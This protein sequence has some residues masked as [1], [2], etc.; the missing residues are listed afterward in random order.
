[1]LLTN[2]E[3]KAETTKPRF[4]SNRAETIGEMA[5]ASAVASNRAS[6]ITASCAAVTSFFSENHCGSGILA[7]AACAMAV[8]ATASSSAPS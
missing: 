6:P 2:S 4:F 1:M 5:T 3:A 7:S 8:R